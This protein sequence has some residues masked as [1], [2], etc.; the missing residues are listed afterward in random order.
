M[1]LQD[2]QG[3]ECLIYLDDVIVFSVSFKE[4][5][6]RL[7]RV[8]DALQ[9]AHFKVKTKQ[10]PLCP[11]GSQ[12]WD[13]LYQKKVL[14]Q[15]P[16]KLK[17]FHHTHH[18]KTQRSLSDS[19]DY[20]TTIDAL[21]QLCKIAEPLNKLVNKDQRKF[22]S[23]WDATCQAAFDQL[24][25]KL[26]TAPILSY[27]DFSLPFVLHTD[28]SDVAIGGILSQCH[29]GHETVICY[30]SR[31]LTK[32]EKNY[33]TVEREALAAVSAIKEFYPYLMGFHSLLSLTITH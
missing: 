30:W 4:H 22:T 10:M 9:K 16:V 20:Q 24:K 19:L 23:G 11:E 27:P 17:Q 3:E 15:T 21:L 13:T 32:A 26:T 29:D 18:H 12:I 33:S 25:C 8:F 5:L 2:C 14:P 1:C 31:Q 7:A 6:E 28:A